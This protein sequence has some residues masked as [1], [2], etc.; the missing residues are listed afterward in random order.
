MVLNTNPENIKAFSR[1]TLADITSGRFAAANRALATPLKDAITSSSIFLGPGEK[2]TF[3][4]YFK[5]VGK[6]KY[7]VK[8][9]P[10]KWVSFNVMEIDGK[11]WIIGGLQWRSSDG[12]EV[13]L[14]GMVGEVENV[15]KWG[16]YVSDLLKGDRDPSLIYKV[17]D[18]CSKVWYGYVGVCEVY[19]RDNNKQTELIKKWAEKGIL[20]PE[21]QNYLVGIV[22][23]TW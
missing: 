5:D 19:H 16:S 12:S 20:P 10:M 6:W 21:L 14:A 15:P 22:A 13:F 8:T 11:D 2:L 17:G 9:R 18:D 7:D 4:G 3:A 23:S 1:I